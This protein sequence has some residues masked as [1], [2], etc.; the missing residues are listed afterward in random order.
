MTLLAE[1]ESPPLL[2]RA[3]RAAADVVEVEEGGGFLASLLVMPEAVPVARLDRSLDGAACEGAV[4]RAVM[5][6]TTGA[7]GCGYFVWRV[8]S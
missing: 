8:D 4:L 5:L 3:L 7:R 6:T 2:A 1:V